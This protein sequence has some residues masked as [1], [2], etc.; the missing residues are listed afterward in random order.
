MNHILGIKLDGDR[1]FDKPVSLKI[2]IIRH[3]NDQI[4]WLYSDNGKSRGSFKKEIVVRGGNKLKEYTWIY[5][6]SV[7]KLS[8]ANR[9]EGLESFVNSEDRLELLS[10]HQMNQYI[11]LI[12]IDNPEADILSFITFNSI[13]SSYWGRPYSF[14]LYF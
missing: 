10:W 13:D 14:M 3:I 11:V 8:M 2:G 12:G 9:E 7:G 4:L 1:F 6:L 5:K